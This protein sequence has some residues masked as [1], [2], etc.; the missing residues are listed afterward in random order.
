MKALIIILSYIIIGLIFATFFVYL[1]EKDK[2]LYKPDS[3]T[4]FILT[5]MGWPIMVPT[6]A[7]GYLGL[8]VIDKIR[9]FVK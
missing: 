8:F 5:F 1:N 4:I 7:I 9:S 3:E 2:C 6:V